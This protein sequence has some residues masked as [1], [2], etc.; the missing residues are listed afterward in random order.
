MVSGGGGVFFFG[1]ATGS[2]EARTA[3]LLVG[4]AGFASRCAAS[5][6]RAGATDITHLFCMYLAVLLPATRGLIAAP[7]QRS[8]VVCIA[9]LFGVGE[10]F[11]WLW[12]CPLLLYTAR[13]DQSRQPWCVPLLP[14]VMTIA[15]S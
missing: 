8:G 14:R 12:R 3:G 5:A 7:V 11:V 1:G 6:A 13:E 15:T 9:V 2:R 10:A 4:D